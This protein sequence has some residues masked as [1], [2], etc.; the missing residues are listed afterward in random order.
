[1]KLRLCS[2]LALMLLGSAA[3]ALAQDADAGAPDATPPETPPTEGVAPAAPEAPPVAEP[4][5]KAE[6]PATTA[7]EAKRAAAEPSAVQRAPAAPRE[8]DAASGQSFVVRL[9]ASPEHRIR[10]IK[11]GSLIR[12]WHGLQWPHYEHTGLPLSGDIWIDSGYERQV[13]SLSTE[14]NR[15]F[16][17]QSGRFRLRATPTYTKGSMFVQAQGEVLAWSD[18][19]RGNLP[20]DVD[21][22]WVKFGA[23]NVWDIQFGR[24]EAWEVYHKGMGLDLYTLEYNGAFDDR[25]TTVVQLY[26]VGYLFYRQDGLGQLALHLYPTDWLRFEIGA[27]MGNELGLNAIGVRPVGILDLGWMK[28]KVGAEYRLAQ[29]WQERMPRKDTRRG[30]GGALQFIIDPL[31][32][33]GVNGAYAVVDQIGPDG[34][35]NEQGSITPLSIGG[36]VNTPPVGDLVL[37][38]GVNHTWQ[39]DRQYNDQVDDVG[40]F[41][42]FQVFGAIQHPIISD[43]LTAKLVVSYAKANLHPS[44]DNAK[45]NVMYS[46]RLRLL[47]LF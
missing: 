20:I 5:Q 16:W 15:H 46:A 31:L 27:V 9:P 38:G 43:D 10:G 23:W 33:F 36:F 22:A 26:E 30:A 42:H 4:A 3:P 37:G 21:D 24:Y 35:V 28:F 34:R 17:L 39:D 47:Y 32:E 13:R 14:G 18:P 25:D 44:Y 12:I 41:Q 1:M 8:K 2:A 29:D 7:Q 6:P 19:V 40:H 11:D 45:E